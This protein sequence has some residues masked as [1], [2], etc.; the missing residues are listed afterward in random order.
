MKI[1]PSGMWVILCIGFA[2][3]G[4]TELEKQEQFLHEMENEIDSLRVVRDHQINKNAILAS[5]IQQIQT[6][7][8]R[9]YKDHRRLEKQL[10]EAQSLNMQIK[11][12]EMQ[13][14]NLNHLYQ[15]SLKALINAYERRLNQ[16]MILAKKT[17]SEANREQ[18]LRASQD[19]LAKKT[20]WSQ[21]ITAPS[22]PQFSS[23]PINR[24][25]WDN[26][27]SL[28]L[29][30]DALLDQEQAVHQEIENL[31]TKIKH[32][33]EEE[34]LRNKMAELTGDLNLFS[35]TEE[36]MD[37]VAYDGHIQ[38]DPPTQEY[39]G[40]ESV[41]SNSKIF[42]NERNEKPPLYP[43]LQQDPISKTDHDVTLSISDRIQLLKQYRKKLVVRSD[44]LKQKARWFENQA[45][46]TVNTQTQS[47]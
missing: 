47:Q 46:K 11:Q 13:I 4:Q 12:T 21:Y 2:L 34:N 31:N 8:E 25:P 10:R 28:Q 6:G 17:R 22:P 36:T 26:T 15:D 32:L 37:R 35:E 43:F 23:F 42:F 38:D 7:E 27:A 30:R 44:S 41:D 14:L 9:S 45:K 16:L 1:R 5:Q 19:I 40:W 39:T 18:Y 20:Y 3:L 24:A 29:K 33:Q